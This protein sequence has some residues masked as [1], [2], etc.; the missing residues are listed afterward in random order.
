MPS[1]SFAA[2][3]LVLVITIFVRTTRGH[4]RALA[5]P[6]L[7]HMVILPSALGGI[8]REPARWR[9][10]GSPIHHNPAVFS[11]ISA[12]QIRRSRTPA[13]IDLMAAQA[14]SAGRDL[15]TSFKT[16]RVSR[17][18]FGS[19]PALFPDVE[20][21]NTTC[22]SASFRNEL[23]PFMG[24]YIDVTVLRRSSQRETW[25]D[26]QRRCPREPPC[27]IPLGPT[28]RCDSP[29]DGNGSTTHRPFRPHNPGSQPSNLILQPTRLPA[30][31]QTG[32]RNQNVYN[33]GDQFRRD[34]DSPKTSKAGA[35]RLMGNRFSANS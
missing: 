27:S 31:G 35:P 26:F 1:L 2:G 25:L 16:F 33:G 23:P 3:K 13:T 17:Y 11:P 22:P 30:C 20:H 32:M 6:G 8:F 28:Q 21:C 34:S 10:T 24:D 19:V 14:E 15:S 7:R 18:E 29:A 9:R 12:I 4:I 5:Q